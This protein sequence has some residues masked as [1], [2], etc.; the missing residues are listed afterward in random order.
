MCWFG[1]VL[2]PALSLLLPA[3]PFSSGYVLFGSCWVSGLPGRRPVCSAYAVIGGLA[4]AQ[5]PAKLLQDILCIQLPNTGSTAAFRLLNCIAPE[6]ALGILR[7]RCNA[8]PHPGRIQATRPATKLLQ[9]FR[10]KL[11]QKT[12]SRLQIFYYCATVHT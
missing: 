6:S 8:L 9:N 3:S 7:L 11:L 4:P 1:Y 12:R 2:H 10:G 5:P